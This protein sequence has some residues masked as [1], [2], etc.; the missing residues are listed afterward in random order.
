M[1][2]RSINFPMQRTRNSSSKVG[3]TYQS[4]EFHIAVQGFSKRKVSKTIT[5]FLHGEY[6]NKTRNQ[7]WD[8]EAFGNFYVNGMNAGDYTAY[9]SLQRLLSKK[10]GYLQLGFQNTNR[11]PSF[12]FDPFSGFWW[13]PSQTLSKENITNIFGAVDVPSL[14]LKLSGNYYLITNLAY[15]RKLHRG[16]PA[17][18][19]IQYPAR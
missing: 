12:V 5:F 4:L 14:K 15:F 19:S 8:I 13:N 7:K 2:S 1:I 16:R 10:I 18:H 11:T 3:A 9:V 6:R 17:K